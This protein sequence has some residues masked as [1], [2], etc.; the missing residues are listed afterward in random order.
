MAGLHLAASVS[1]S[2]GCVYEKYE[3]RGGVKAKVMCDLWDHPEFPLSVMFPVLVRWTRQ[4]RSASAVRGSTSESRSSARMQRL[5]SRPSRKPWRRS[6]SNP[7]L[8]LNSRFNSIIFWRC[9]PAV[10]SKA[11][12]LFFMGDKYTACIH[13]SSHKLILLSWLRVSRDTGSPCHCIWLSCFFTALPVASFC[14]NVSAESAKCVCCNG[15]DLPYM[16]SLLRGITKLL[17]KAF[18]LQ[19]LSLEFWKYPTW[20]AALRLL[21]VAIFFQ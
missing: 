16:H 5:E 4:R 12:F 1:E 18:N 10:I 15:C 21:W 19:W 3:S 13:T 9:V 6:S 14:C 17:V 11:I 20:P 7:N 8:T 2:W